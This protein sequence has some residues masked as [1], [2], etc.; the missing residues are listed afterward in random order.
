MSVPCKDCGDP[1]QH[2]QKCQFHIK[3]ENRTIHPLCQH[4]M[5][6]RVNSKNGIVLSKPFKKL[7]KRD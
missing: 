4:C 7:I 2:I 3:E 1:I 6:I 5:D